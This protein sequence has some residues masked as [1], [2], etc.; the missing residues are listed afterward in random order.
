MTKGFKVGIEFGSVL[1]AIS[2]QIYETPLAFIREN[3]Q[4]AVDAVRM[5]AKREGV[6]PGG[7][8]LAVHVTA[9]Q[10]AVE[11][12]DNGVGM[13]LADLQNL[14]WTIGASGKRTPEARAA[15]CVGMFGIGGFANFG[16][17]GALSV[18]AQAPDESTGHETR[19]SRDDIESAGGSIPEVQV[20]ES[21]EAAPRGTLVRGT[22]LEP[23]NVDELGSY[24]RDFVRYAEEHVFFN[25]ELI[26]RQPY[27]ALISKTDVEPVSADKEDWAHGNLV[28]Q[29]QLWASRDHT[30]SAELVDLLVDGESVRLKGWLR[31]ENGPI[32][33]LKRGFKLCS[34]AVGTQIGVSGT[35]DCDLL[36]PTAGRDSLDAE[37]A[38]LVAAIVSCLERAAV[39]AV[40][41]SS[42]RIAQ[43]TRIFRYVRSQGLVGHLG[44]T[45]VELA[46]GSES[47]LA[48]IQ[49]RSSHGVSVFYANSKNARLAHLLQTRGHIVVQ[50]PSDNH[51]QIAIRE[52]LST[53]CN[54]EPFEGRVELVEEYSELNRFEK[55]FLSE[56]EE[57][58][59]AGFEVTSTHLIPGKL[60]EDIPVYAPDV[61]DSTLS[62][63]ADV[64]HSEIA[65]LEALGSSGLFRSMVAAFCREYLGPTLRAHSPKFFGSGAVNLEFLSK[66]RSELWV[67]LSD[68]IE[69]L[70]RDAR[71]DV[72]RPSD[73]RVVQAGGS[74]GGSAQEPESL[75]GQREPKLIRIEGSLE[76]TELFG[77]YLRIPRSAAVAYGDVIQQCEERAAVWAGNKILLFASDGISTAFQ[78]EVRLDELIVGSNDKL[79]GGAGAEELTRPVQALF[80]G[81]YFPIPPALE[82]Y[83]VPQP[84]EEIRIEVRSDWID[85]STARSWRGVDVA[86]EQHA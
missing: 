76:F 51:K 13:N 85:F 22:L 74:G 6:S 23:A 15:G 24:L 58:I 49:S 55:L 37:S 8:G 84:N 7:E 62:I 73:V 27:E 36:S 83:L 50:L 65:K 54:A 72:V 30:L 68:E 11:I 28:V 12:R 70:T 43:H 16:V 10:S 3:V 86:E 14:F 67:L 35:L 56:L 5:Q 44:N 21:E 9:D 60:S 81:L 64:R 2:K 48:D 33:V 82:P 32:D 66:R 42:E 40:L 18:T 61:V 47:R 20:S 80:E 19:L 59:L 25:G 75:D 41:E 63:F 45:T 31:F 52:F 46:D 4:N 77:Y 39:L 26:S 1:A 34:T 17:C 69:V 57:T 53:Y 79:G 71:R 78:F 29:G 38:S